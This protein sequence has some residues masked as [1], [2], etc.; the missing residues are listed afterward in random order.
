MDEVNRIKDDR[1]ATAAVLNKIELDSEKYRLGLTKACAMAI[2]DP[3]PKAAAPE[4]RYQ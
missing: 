3:C 4:Y 1:E 2:G